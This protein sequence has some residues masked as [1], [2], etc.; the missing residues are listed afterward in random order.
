MINFMQ[1]F[2][3]LTSVLSI[4]QCTSQNP[5]DRHGPLRISENG[6]TIEHEDGQPFLWLGDTGWAMFQQ[7]SRQEIDVYLDHRK[8]KGFTLIQAVAFWYPHGNDLPL[9]PLN[10][11]NAYGHRPFH[12]DAEDPDTSVPLVVT[13]GSPHNPNDYWDHA[14]YVVA[15]TKARGLYLALLPCWGNAFINNRMPG[16]RIEFT[17]TEARRYGQFLGQRYRN[18]PH[19]IWVLGGDVDPVNFGDQD[20][21]PVYRAMAEGIGRGVSGNQTLQFNVPHADWDQTF[22]T[23]HAVQAPYLSNGARGGSSSIWFHH[24]AWLDVNMMETFSWLDRIYP[25]VSEDY[26]RTDPVK[27]T[28]HGEGAYEEGKYGHDCGWLTPLRVRRQAYHAFF[29]GAAGHTY[30]HWS[31]WPFRGKNCEKTWSEALDAPGAE[32][33]ARVLKTFLLE[34]EWQ[35]LIP[36]QSII[37]SD[38]GNGEKLVCSMRTIDFDKIY[39]YFSEIKP[40][41]IDPQR[42]EAAHNFKAIWFDPATGHIQPI[43]SLQTNR[44][45]PPNIWQDAVLVLEKEIE[46]R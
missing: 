32:H 8:E 9:G 2:G 36:D 4:L 21:R 15:A 30:G 14:D 41:E 38:P 1:K 26:Q 18:E 17:E 44:F 42:F 20:Q 10:A 31:I 39:I 22:M 34:H 43:A 7:L 28:I 11:A 19:I 29:A 40:I 33:I 35:R 24:D 25:L 12:G 6:H 5:W 3:F 37:L 45:F 13:E 23:F 46:T 27:P 16:S